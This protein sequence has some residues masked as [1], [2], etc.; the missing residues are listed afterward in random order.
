MGNAMVLSVNTYDVALLTK[1]KMA[2]VQS[3]SF[4]ETFV[5][6]DRNIIDK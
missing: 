6:F 2:A 3:P 1:S 5:I 4:R